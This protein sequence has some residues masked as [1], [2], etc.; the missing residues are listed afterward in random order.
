M[1]IEALRDLF[2]SGSPL[3]KEL[4]QKTLNDVGLFSSLLESQFTEE[5]RVLRRI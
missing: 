4:R 2:K 3:C 5:E 1:F